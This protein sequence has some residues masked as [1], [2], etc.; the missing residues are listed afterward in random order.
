VNDDQKKQESALPKQLL[1][2]RSLRPLMESFFEKMPKDQQVASVRLGFQELWNR[3]AQYLS[4]EDLCKI[5]EAA[6]FACCA[7]GKQI[8][9]SGEPYVIH[10]LCAAAILAE[11]RLDRDTS[12]PHCCTMCLR[13]P[14]STQ[15]N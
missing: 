6:V 4:K 2:D 15:R 1:N 8:R 9:H 10:T 11:M 3:A 7:H 5:G 12:S 13:I 14:P